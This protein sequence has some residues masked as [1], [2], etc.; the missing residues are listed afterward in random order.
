VQQPRRQ[1]SSHK[2][3]VCADYVN[4]L[5]DNIN[6]MKKN[7][8]ALAGVSKE[9]GLEVDATKTKYRLISRHQTIRQNHFIKGS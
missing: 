4:L 9:G 6:I 7:T 3:L 1:L 2:L 5:G 8:E